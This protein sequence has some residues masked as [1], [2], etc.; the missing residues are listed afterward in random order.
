MGE[1]LDLI[2]GAMAF[3]DVLHRSGISDR[4]TIKLSHSDGE[5]LLATV[6]GSNASIMSRT[7]HEHADTVGLTR[8]CQLGGLFFEWPVSPSR[9]ETPPSN[10]GKTNTPSW[11]LEPPED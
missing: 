5:A 10:G 1:V 7:V 9:D 11:L 2:R 6:T 8:K 4:I 3:A